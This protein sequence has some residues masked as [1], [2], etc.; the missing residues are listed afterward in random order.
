MELP[1]KGSPG[2]A[3]QIPVCLGLQRDGC[4]EPA[5]RREGMV[6]LAQMMSERCSPATVV[7][8]EGSI[9]LEEGAFFLIDP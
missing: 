2:V 7:P 1:R 6:H 9:C 3:H 4:V 5:P 8:P